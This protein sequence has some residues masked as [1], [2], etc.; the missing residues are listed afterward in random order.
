MIEIVTVS[1]IAL[2]VIVQTYALLTP[3]EAMAPVRIGTSFEYTVYQSAN[4]DGTPMLTHW[5]VLV[6]SETAQISELLGEVTLT[7][8][9][10][11]RVEK[12]VSVPLTTI[13]MA[14]ED[15]DRELSMV[16][17]TVLSPLTTLM[18]LVIGVA[19]NVIPSDE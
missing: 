19:S 16:Q 18:L 15:G 1:P 17:P 3:L 2:D 4:G 9:T 12:F 13:S 11:N 6:T 7:P 8:P 5:M 14:F 10:V